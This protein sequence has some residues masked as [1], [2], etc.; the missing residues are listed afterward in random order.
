MGHVFEAAIPGVADRYTIER[1]LGRGGMATVFLAHDLRHD[2][3]VA[4]KL[5]RAELAAS[6]GP[7]RFQREIRL[8]ARLQHPHILPVFDSGGSH[9]ALWYTMPY[10]SGHSLSARVAS[11]QPLPVA[12][13]VRILRDVAGALAHAHARGVIHRDVKPA[14]VLL[15]DGHALVMDFGI[16]KAIGDAADSELTQ[17]GYALGT[18]AYMAP[19][20]AGAEPSV[21]HRA[22]IYA[23]GVLGYALLTGEPPFRGSVNELM[24]AHATRKPE[25]INRCRPEVPPA[26]ADLVMQCLEKDPADR[27]QSSDEI[28]SR[29]D[30]L[31]GFDMT[32]TP[33]ASP[34]SPPRGALEAGRAAFDRNEWSAAF[35]HFSAA[36]ELEP[37][38]LVRFAEAAWWLR[39][40]N[41]CVKTRERAYA[42]YVQRGDARNAAAVA[43]ALAEDYSHWMAR[44]VSKGWIRRAER[45]LEE[46]P[47]SP[48]HGWL[49]RF[50]AMLA[51]EGEHDLVRASALTEEAADIGL[52]LG[53][54]DL[55]ALTL[56]DQ[57]RIL[58][59]QGEI[60]EGMSLID[61]AMA[62]AAAGELGPR[63]TGRVYCNMMMACGQLADYGRA[64]EWNDAAK[65]WG[66]PYEQS[67]FP[68]ICRVHR[69]ELLRLRGDLTE[70]EAE[71]RRA[72]EEVGDLLPDVAGEAY[73]EMGEARLR[74]GDFERADALF[75][76]AHRRGRHPL[77]GLALLRLAEG[78]TQAAKNLIDRAMNDRSM[79]RLE[80]GRLLPAFIEI[81][82]ACNTVEAARASVEELGAIANIYGTSA[83]SASATLALGMVEL[84][85]GKAADAAESLRRAQR[86]WTAI[87]L[88][89]EAAR[90]RVLLAQAY[91]A[92]GHREEAEL[93][94]DAAVAVFE[95]LGARADLARIT[96]PHG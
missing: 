41:E 95:R 23:L 94:R 11:G 15:S 82:I 83:L 19:E 43:I 44:S 91:E 29:L 96:E 69:A 33:G 76:D 75:R 21:D 36:G 40:G 31:M 26:L 79:A 71:A 48:E 5:L 14:N 10:V 68:G 65:Q 80:R 24:A 62:A 17:P 61:D 85:E 81:A 8:A 9:G 53:D 28:R 7:E 2:R 59:A 46:T 20:Q 58:V 92:M 18:P 12:E 49:V 87:D 72:A 39:K 57:G 78:Q 63:T 6:I 1:E 51:L 30:Q 45:H 16:A 90:S 93:E 84:A 37:D 47:E 34:V 73:Y 38:D 13:A 74:M 50:K 22:D 32:P 86:L 55:R 27:C 3:P 35:E 52:R 54:P 77:P 25:P 42:L 67:A 89:Y 70:A 56:Q 88:P 66:E 60:G 4:L 64:A